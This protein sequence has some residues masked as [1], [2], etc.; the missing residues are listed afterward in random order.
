MV[1]SS[2]FT[3]ATSEE[4]T[5]ISTLPPLQLLKAEF[6][7]R[8]KN[9]HDLYV[10]LNG[11]REW[12]NEHLKNYEIYLEDEWYDDKTTIEYTFRCLDTL[13]IIIFAADEYSNHRDEKGVWHLGDYRRSEWLLTPVWDHLEQFINENTALK[14]L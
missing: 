5:D 13:N 2:S 4:S 8:C 14:L 9:S 10:V 3:T 12:V 11:F 1:H 7:T 6:D